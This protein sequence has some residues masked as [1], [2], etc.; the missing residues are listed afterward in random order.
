LNFDGDLR[1]PFSGGFL[2]NGLL[3]GGFLDDTF[4]THSGTDADAGGFDPLTAPPRPRRHTAGGD[5]TTRQRAR[6]ERSAQL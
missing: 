1:Q 4:A 2:D 5:G 3:D 6:G